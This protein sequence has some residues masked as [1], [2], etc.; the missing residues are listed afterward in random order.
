[1]SVAAISSFVAFSIGAAVP[2]VPY[3]LGSVTVLLPLLLT[4]VALFAC[5]A[6][7]TRLTNRSWWFGGLRQVLL[8]AVAFAATY[9]IGAAIGTQV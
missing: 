6:V 9:G 3:L 4:L 7:V 8:G 5:G 1:M 2:L